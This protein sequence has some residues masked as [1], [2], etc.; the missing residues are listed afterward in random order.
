AP[1]E[2][3][4]RQL[5]L[6]LA[7]E[8]LIGTRDLLAAAERVR[9]VEQEWTDIA[10]DVEPRDDVARRFH[11]A[12]ERILDEAGSLA[13]RQDELE[14]RR[15]GRS[16]TTAGRGPPSANASNGSMTPP[17]PMPSTTRTPSGVASPRSR[18]TS[19]YPWRDA[20]GSPARRRR[21]ADSN[22]P[23]G[24]LSRRSSNRW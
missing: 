18:T 10:R 23:P 13:R 6:C 1:K 16:V 8:S 17:H 20:S 14:T 19:S 22:G 9:T 2:G 21:R 12:C 15:R 5:E 24:R 11:K 3:H 4:A 7:V